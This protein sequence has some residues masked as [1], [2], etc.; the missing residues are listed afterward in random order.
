LRALQ[1]SGIRVLEQATVAADTAV[2]NAIHN[3]A[4]ILDQEIRTKTLKMGLEGATK[5]VT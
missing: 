3:R 4:N 1:D 5:I 2:N